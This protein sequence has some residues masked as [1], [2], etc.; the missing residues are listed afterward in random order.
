MISK[1]K[2][3]NNSIILFIIFVIF[4]IL[5][6][7]VDVGSVGPL[8]SEV[9]FSTINKSV[10]DLLSYNDIFYKISKYLGYVSFLIIGMYGIIGLIQLIKRKSIF[11]VDK[12]LLTI[13]AFYVVVL[14]VYALF[15]FVVI[16]Y[17]PVLE[18]GSLE[19][20]YPSSHTILSVCVCFSSILV[21]KN[22]FK[23]KNIIKLLNI[24]CYI[25]MFAIITT[26]LLSGVHWLTDI[27]GGILISYSLCE[28][29]R[30][31][32]NKLK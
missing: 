11:K 23:N 26:R 25:L 2:K 4:T 32:I 7:V 24:F 10:H 15:E 14:F 13:G 28:L 9:G 16:N 17:R 19:A 1:D 29:F 12:N 27:I 20:S 5:V 30:Y 22:I 3:I 21:S 6:K 31:L 18:N 8:G